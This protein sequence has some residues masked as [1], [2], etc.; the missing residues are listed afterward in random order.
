MRIKLWIGLFLI[1]LSFYS[2]G[3]VSCDELFENSCQKIFHYTEHFYTVLPFFMPILGIGIVLVWK[4]G[5]E[6]E[7]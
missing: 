1:F 3:P 4:R 5:I 2:I 6:N 7:K